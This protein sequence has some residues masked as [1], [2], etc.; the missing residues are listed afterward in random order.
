MFA[1]FD[2]IKIKVP[3][4]KTICVGYSIE[5]D[6]F[7]VEAEGGGVVVVFRETQYLIPL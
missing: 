2:C 5:I 6:S 7:L 4:I 3:K 1:H